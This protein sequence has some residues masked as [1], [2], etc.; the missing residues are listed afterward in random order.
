MLKPKVSEYKVVRGDCLWNIADD[1]YGNPTVWPDIAKLNHLPDPDLILIGM[2][3]KL[4]PVHDRRYHRRPPDPGSSRKANAKSPNVIGVDPSRP[5]RLDQ[6]HA[7]DM[8]PPAKGAT[9]LPQIAPPNPPSQLSPT[10]TGT[11]TALA[12]PLLFPAV[13]YK[14]DD[15][16]AITIDTPAMTITLRFVGEISLQQK[17]T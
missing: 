4:G 5:L 7:L 1:Q 10:P 15:L 11:G 2:T 3:L 16:A 13:R 12:R 9:R 6:P 8:G 17:G 14:L